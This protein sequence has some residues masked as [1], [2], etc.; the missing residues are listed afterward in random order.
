MPPPRE[1]AA[2]AA[3]LR[4]HAAPLLGAAARLA[5]AARARANAA[6]AGLEPWQLLLAG[7]IAALALHRLAR[8]VKAA[9]H[10][11][12]DKGPTQLAA[13]WALRLPLLRGAV[14][15]RQRAAM[16]EVR[17]S[18]AARERAA[19]GG[20]ALAP[21]PPPLR[22]LPERGA[23]AAE[24]RARLDALAAADEPFDAARP[25]RASGALYIA[26][27]EHEALLLG[28]YAR[29]ALTNPLHPGL[30][31]SVRRMEA[32]VV[33]QCVALM[34][35][36]PGTGAPDACGAMTAGGSESILLAVKAARGAA[37]ARGVAEP[38]IVLADS[39][40]PAYLKGAAYFG[41]SVVRARAGADLR[42]TGAGVRAALSRRSAL[43][44]ASAPG[45]PHGVIDDV[46]SVAAAA[47]A[48]GVPCHVD[49]CLGGFILPFARDLGRPVPPFDFAVPGVTS[50]SIDTHKFG[51]AH[52]GTSAVLY[53]SPALRRRQ[54]VACTDWPG[55]LYISP[56]FA[57]SRPGAL[58]ATAWA[59]LAHRG[60]AGFRAAAAAALAEAD[61][62]AAGVGATEGLEVLG[63]P[64]STLV[65]FRAAPPPKGRSRG[66]PAPPALNVYRV[67]DFLS[68]RGWHLNAL[69]RPPALHFC[70]TAAHAPGT[71]AA[72]VADL[73]AAVAA[74]RA[75]GVGSGDE[76]GGSAPLYGMA[77]TAPDRGLVA[78]FL[79][80]Y[81][82]ALLEP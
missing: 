54:Y 62:L 76:G 61:A 70:F 66:E 55:G 48:A 46:A 43:V 34:G 65:A 14:A 69:Q 78:D 16:A 27:A 33:A 67:N 1:A 75:R 30:W 37:A 2:A 12:V 64:G 50:I 17:A 36:G 4:R 80:G 77:A 24:V 22:A 45:F 31:P 29:F 44:V 19:P 39:A 6:L 23:P 15:A 58:V 47:A 52:K 21:P 53:R 60:R 32:E 18:L 73:R 81:Q 49:C 82:D 74:E 72:L 40:H 28:A 3:L 35:G 13:A 26:D 25:S 68:K 8:A 5:V 10:A 11:L 7:F 63:A 79:T 20:A 51:Q 9:R 59:S 41:L 71:A 42:L 38:E 56:G 57:G